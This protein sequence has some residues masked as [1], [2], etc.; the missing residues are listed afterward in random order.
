MWTLT[1]TLVSC[2]CSL[3]QKHVA[4]SASGH[5]VSLGGDK[6]VL[7]LGYGSHNSASI[8]KSTELY[9]VSGLTLWGINYTIII[10]CFFLSDGDE[11]KWKQKV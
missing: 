9:T 5:K 1:G 11:R 8:L 4:F 2:C 10:N 3:D 6:S 7:N